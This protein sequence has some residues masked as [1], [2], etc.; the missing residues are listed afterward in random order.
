MLRTSCQ[1]THAGAY[2]LT[3]YCLCVVR[4]IAIIQPLLDAKQQRNPAWLSWTKHVQIVTM[5]V[6]HS[7]TRE[8]LDKIDVLV[9]EHAKLFDEALKIMPIIPPDTS[10]RT[11]DPHK[12]RIARWGITRKTTGQTRH[13]SV[14]TDIQR[15]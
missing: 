11:H 14:S 4:S 10:I 7:I 1:P 3:A 2:L 9:E 6:Q 12:K 8:D 5:A 15:L 13:R